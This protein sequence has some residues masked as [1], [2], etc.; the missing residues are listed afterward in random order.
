MFRMPYST[1]YNISSSSTFN[2]CLVSS[3]LTINTKMLKL[4]MMNKT[5]IIHAGRLAHRKE[6][7]TKA[8]IFLEVK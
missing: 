5:R 3:S 8:D 6:A 1:S 7:L 4:T 2:Y